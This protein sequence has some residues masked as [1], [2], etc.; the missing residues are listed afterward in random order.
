MKK[1][2]IFVLDGRST[3]YSW[4]DAL[5]CEYVENLDISWEP[6]EDSALLITAQHYKAP[7]VCIL[8]RA[9]EQG[10]PTLVI[11]DGILEY[12]N[13]WEN[14][15][16]PPGSIFQPVVGHKIA[17]LGR[18]QARFLESWGNIDKC[19]VVGAPRLD[20]L[21]GK[22]PRIRK[23]GEPFRI[24]I[25]TARTPG[26]TPQ[27]MAVAKR[28]LQD[29]KFWFSIHG[30]VN[31]IEIKP[32][33][34]ITQGLD[35][36]LDVENSL[37]GITGKEL[38]EVLSKVDAAI[39]T[40]S[41]TTLE[42]MLIGIPVAIIDYN[43]RPAYVRT[44]WNITAPRHIDQIIPELVEPTRAR[45]LFQD[46]IL[47]DELECRT[48]ATPRMIKLAEEMIR[49]GIECC[50]SSQPLVFPRRILKSNSDVCHMPEESFDLAR[51]YPNHPV[52]SEMDR[53]KLQV[54]TGHLKNL[55]S[56]QQEEINKFRRQRTSWQGNTTVRNTNA[57]LQ[58]ILNSYSRK[59]TV[60]L[61]SVFA[62]F[63][64]RS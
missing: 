43:N 18:S 24:L 32:F 10:I 52:F 58:K 21:L 13:T 11:S 12:R 5:D 16:I 49:I 31:G 61:R 35:K 4:A 51:L 47:H 48:P 50:A 30:K 22:K 17:V 8:N 45:M 3:L 53:A 46:T 33:W 59:I 9:F 55:I 39:T 23:D 57:R 26:F 40:P 1:N 62:M 15:G 34:R 19:E 63:R 41:T 28:G 44:A 2:R 42:A 29:L 37:T 56:R 60:P 25:M 20:R 38:S 7:E 64:N 36:E 27:Q 14:P 6:P 54:E